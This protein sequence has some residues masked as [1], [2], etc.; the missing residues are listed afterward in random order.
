MGTLFFDNSPDGGAR[1][2][3]LFAKVLGD[4][5]RLIDIVGR[6]P[7]QEVD[8]RARRHLFGED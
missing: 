7:D 8:E 5:S 1:R 2:A 4:P 3:R 6:G